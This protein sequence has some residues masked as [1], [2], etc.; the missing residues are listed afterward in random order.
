MPDGKM[1][2]TEMNS[3][4]HYAYGAVIDWIYSV[5]GGINPVEDAPGYEKVLIAPI[6]DR[7]ID[8]LKVELKTKHGVIKSAWKHEGDKVIYEISTPTKATIVIEGK[9]HRVEAGTYTF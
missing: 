2:S 5:S 1:W 9:T 4:N 8:W 3:F 6:A 7:R